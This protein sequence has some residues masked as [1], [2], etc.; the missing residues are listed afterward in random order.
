[1]SRT[2]K[3]IERHN[4]SKIDIPSVRLGTSE[5]ERKLVTDGNNADRNILWICAKKIAVGLRAFATSQTGSS[6]PVSSYEQ[7][8]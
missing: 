3:A 4:D 8:C 6:Q 2:I 1:M 7:N 5:S